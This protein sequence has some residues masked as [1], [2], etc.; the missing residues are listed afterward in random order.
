MANTVDVFRV[1]NLGNRTMQLSFEGNCG[2]IFWGKAYSWLAQAF[3]S[4][5]NEQS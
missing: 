2:V 4:D 3:M 1:H 5:I